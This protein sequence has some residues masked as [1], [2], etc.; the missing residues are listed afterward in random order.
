MVDEGIGHGEEGVVVG[1]GN[2]NEVR[3]DAR[4]NDRGNE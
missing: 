1:I 3:V 4:R 2:G